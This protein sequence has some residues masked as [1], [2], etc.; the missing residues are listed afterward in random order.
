MGVSRWLN[1]P[2]STMWCDYDV[3]KISMDCD[4]KNRAAMLQMPFFIILFGVFSNS[5]STPNMSSPFSSQILTQD[6]ITHNTFILTSP[7]T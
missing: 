7:H 2:S 1:F 3:I 4:F 6:F 5:A